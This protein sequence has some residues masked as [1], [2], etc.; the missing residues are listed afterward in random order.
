VRALLAI[1]FLT[2]TGVLDIAPDG[3]VIVSKRARKCFLATLREELQD[4][5]FVALDADDETGKKASD[6]WLNQCAILT[7]LACIQEVTGSA[8]SFRLLKAC[9]D[10]FLV[11]SGASAAREH[12]VAE[13]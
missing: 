9:V 4:E 5:R 3:G 2:L 12:A 10:V 1:D 6:S 11:V 13:D 7:V 8:M